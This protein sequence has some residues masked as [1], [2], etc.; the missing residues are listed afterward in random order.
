MKFPLYLL[1]VIFFSISLTAQPSLQWQKVLGGSDYEDS[2]SIIQ[3]N[4]GGYVVCGQI[5]STDGDGLGNHGLND[6]CIYKLDGNGAVEWKR[7]LGGSGNEIANDVYQTSDNG[8]IMVGTTQSNDGDVTDFHGYIDA[9]VVKIDSM[10]E[11]EWQKALGGSGW[12]EAW[13]VEQTQDGGYILACRTNSDDGDVDGAHNGSF[14]FWV[15]KLSS[16]GEIEWQKSLGGSNDDL[17]WSVKNTSDGGYI[18]TGETWS[19]DGDV[20]GFNGNVDVWVVKIDNSGT[21]QWEHALGGSG[22][23]VGCKVDEV[24]DG[25]IVTC[26]AGSNDGDVIGYHGYLDGWIV[27]LSITGEL[28]WQNSLGGSDSDW[29]YDGAIT[30]DGGYIAVGITA[31]N[32][33]NVQGIHGQFDLWIVKLDSSGSFVW[34][35]CLGG[36]LVD[37]GRTISTTTD[38]GFIVAGH[39]YSTDGDVTENKGI[40]DI[41]VVKLSPESLSAESPFSLIAAEPLEI[42]P[43]PARDFVYLN[44]PPLER[45]SI[46]DVNGKKIAESLTLSSEGYLDVTFLKNGIYFLQGITNSGK[47]YVGKVVKSE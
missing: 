37:G 38:G 29:L 13:S 43:N 44:A 1:F 46:T 26:L 18:I 20:T 35:K 12:D 4:D 16:N 19:N 7:V 9:W 15:V 5:V 23:D 11:L 33:G 41:W 34:Q 42:S 22:L 30:N 45:V 14:D 40:Q 17:A 39:S 36:S 28:L 32:D 21:I 24:K 27:K 2:N 3:T 47:V 6:A 31:S 25:Y 8:Y 10:G